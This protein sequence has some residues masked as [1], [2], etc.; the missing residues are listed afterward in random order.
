MNLTSLSDYTGKLSR[1]R[2]KEQPPSY[3]LIHPIQS[4]YI[5]GTDETRDLELTERNCSSP[6]LLRRNSDI[7]PVNLTF[8]LYTPGIGPAVSAKIN[9]STH[10]P[11]EI[12]RATNLFFE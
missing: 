5:S 2:Y 4:I 8:P 10:T 12:H 6:H 1:R 7:Y 11:P 3:L 9:D